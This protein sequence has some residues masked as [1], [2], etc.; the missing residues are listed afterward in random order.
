MYQIYSTKM[1]LKNNQ[2]EEVN[3]NDLVKGISTTL[4]KIGLGIFRLIQFINLKKYIIL[5]LLIVG[6]LLG[7]VVD[8]YSKGSNFTHELIIT[9]NVDSQA[10]LY[11]EINSLKFNEN[12]S[13]KSVEIEPIIDIFNFMSENSNNLEIAKFLADNNVKLIKHAKGNETEQVYP[14]HLIR[15]YS[16]NYL[17]GEKEI[18]NI[19]N[20]LNK[21]SYFV[22]R[23]HKNQNFLQ[24]KI[25][26]NNISISNINNLFDKLGKNQ[27]SVNSNVNIEV[28]TEINKLI[29]N[30][31]YLLEENKKLEK[32][33]IENKDVIFKLADLKS[34]K[35]TK[36]QNFKFILPIVFLF[37]YFL[38]IGFNKFINKYKQYS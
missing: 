18:N 33:L 24:S 25:Q 36:N 14:Y 20:Q 8:Y 29:E 37:G 15:F 5:I 22:E 13:L 27:P 12:S 35:E 28:F 7:F 26:Q 4:D 31:Q 32:Q 6:G 30:K 9:P 3:I 23:L 21:E 38:L 19:L 34:N 1:D 11:K 2:S 10:F 16:K 17:K